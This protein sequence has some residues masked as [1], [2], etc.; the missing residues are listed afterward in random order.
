MEKTNFEK[1]DI[2]RI[3]TELA[4]IIWKIVITWKYF[5]KDTIGKQLTRAAD[6]VGANIA[7]GC[8]RSSYYDNKRFIYIARGSLNETKH[9]LHMAV[10]RNL[11]TD[12]QIKQIKPLMNEL[13]PRLNAYLTS[14]RNRAVIN[15]QLTTNH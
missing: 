10:N 11:I 6:S 12:K 5:E 13:L 15:E 1:L 4:D 7:E 8:G 9:W 14:V 2:Y 3:A